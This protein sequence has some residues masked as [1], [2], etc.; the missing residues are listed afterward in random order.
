MSGHSHWAGIK[1]KKAV[2]DAKRAQVFTKLGRAISVVA[3][4]GGGNP[5]F[6]PALRLA[7][8]KARSF[9]M[10]GDKIENSVQKGTGESAGNQLEETEYEALGPYGTM[11]MIK[12]ITDNKNR[13]VSEIRRILEKHGGKMADGGISWNFRRAG[14]I[15]ILPDAAQKEVAINLAIEGNAEDVLEKKDG[16]VQVV[17]SLKNLNS[18]KEQLSVF[19]IQESGVGY[20]PQNPVSL[21][22]EQQKKY[23]NLMDELIEHPDVQE[24]YDNISES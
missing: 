17:T 4:N 3:R 22:A 24:V 2:A 9:N 23:G 19:G 14:I 12:T 10:P 7:I 18:L 21:S 8:D 16:S 5:E 13:I 1:H 11:L 15:N 20:T 6:N